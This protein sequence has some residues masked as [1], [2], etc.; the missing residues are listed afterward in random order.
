MDKPDSYENDSGGLRQL[1]PRAIPARCILAV[2]RIH[3]KLLFLLPVGF[4]TGV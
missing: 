4:Y 3:A 1:L 2:Y